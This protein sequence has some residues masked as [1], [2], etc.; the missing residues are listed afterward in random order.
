MGVYTVRLGHAIGPPNLRVGKT[1]EVVSTDRW[2]RQ[3]KLGPS[4]RLPWSIPHSAFRRMNGVP[5]CT[6]MLSD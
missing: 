5:K 6:Y 3:P 1:E 4:N 2:W